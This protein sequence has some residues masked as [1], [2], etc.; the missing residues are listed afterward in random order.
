MSNSSQELNHEFSRDGIRRV[1]AEFP[2]ETIEKKREEWKQ[3]VADLKPYPG[4]SEGKGIVICAG[5]FTYLTCAWINI[6]LLRKKGCSLPVELW[7][8]K[9][10]LTQEMKTE[11]QTLNV[12]C[13]SFSDYFSEAISNGYRLKPLAIL[14]SGFEEILFLDAD[15]NCLRDPA[16]LFQND[17]YKSTGAVF[18]PDYWKTEKKNPVWQIVDCED[19]D[20]VEQES[21]QL[22]I[23]KKK[24]WK[25][26]NLCLF[27]N[28]DPFYYKILWGDKD[29]FRFSWMALR[30]PFH[31]I[32]QGVGA[33]G[34]QQEEIGFV[35]LAMVQH[36][37]HGKPIF[38]HANLLKWDARSSKELFWREIR[39]LRSERQIEMKY[40]PEFEKY[41]LSIEGDVEQIAPESEIAELEEDCLYELEQLRKRSFYSGLVDLMQ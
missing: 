37:F 40:H 36:D 1:N 31:M 23:N 33:L 25:E 2:P 10:E 12:T 34:F 39:R 19:R 20:D 32:E 8:Q 30:T 9:G 27:F 11:L 28:L 17:I 41:F 3:F 15:N 24:C 4:T 5:G 26:L 29:T 18:W 22:Q 35:S 7:Y 6:R 13:R 38:I 21:G 14:H 16:F